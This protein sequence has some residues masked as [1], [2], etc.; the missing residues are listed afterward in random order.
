M[1]SLFF[2]NKTHDDDLIGKLQDSEV[3][4]KVRQKMRERFDSEQRE[5]Q[6][7]FK[8]KLKR[9]VEAA[10]NVITKDLRHKHLKVSENSWYI[11]YCTSL[12]FDLI[13]TIATRN[14]KTRN[15]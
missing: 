5:M 15:I 1:R 2:Y 4:K 10:K 8:K 12:T 7:S 13:A 3:E 11:W 6:E 14:K 9:E